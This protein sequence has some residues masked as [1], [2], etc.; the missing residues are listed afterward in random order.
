VTIERDDAIPP[1]PE[2]LAE[3]DRARAI[4]QEALAV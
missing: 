2:L 4:H 1:V 3:L